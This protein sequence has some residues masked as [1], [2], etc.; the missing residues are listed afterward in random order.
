MFNVPPT[1]K[2]IMKMGPWFRVLSDRLE[3]SGSDSGPLPGGVVY[4]LH[5]GGFFWGGDVSFKTYLSKLIFTI[6]SVVGGASVLTLCMLGNF[7]C[8]CCGLL[9]FFKINVFKKFFQEHY[10]SV[11]QLGSRSGS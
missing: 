7:S 11:K 9:T 8:Y 4:P 1:A 10:Q 2:V 3:E 5:L 6:C